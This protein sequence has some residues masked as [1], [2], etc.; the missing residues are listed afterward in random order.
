MSAEFPL[1]PLLDLSNQRLDE[2]A[3][4]LG[5]LIAGEQEATRR[6]AL[7][8]QYRAEYQARF[9]AAARD[10]LPQRVWNNYRQM[11]D[12]IDEAVAQ[13]ALAVTQTQQRTLAGQ[14]NWLGK[15]GRVKAFETLATRHQT[16]LAREEQRREQKLS[17]EFGARPREGE[18]DH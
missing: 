1:Q 4:Q 7:L 15:Q 14:Q 3:R 8:M 11:L 2:A 18:T 10:G 16:V 9:M 13:A 6:H 17:D 5:E 12:R